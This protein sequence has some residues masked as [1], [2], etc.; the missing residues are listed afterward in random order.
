MLWS[1]ICYLLNRY[2]PTSLPIVA[3]EF[4]DVLLIT[5]AVASIVLS[6][7]HHLCL[8]ILALTFPQHKL[9]AVRIPAIVKVDEPLVAVPTRFSL[10]FRHQH[11][12]QFNLPLDLLLVICVLTGGEEAVDDAYDIGN[13]ADDMR[14]KVHFSNH[15]PNP[16]KYFINSY[17]QAPDHRISDA[18]IELT[19]H[20]TIHLI[21]KTGVEVMR[22]V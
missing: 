3:V 16:L 15:K 1:F 21:L 11:C 8:Y 9:L 14:T 10:H 5:I 4:D 13:G 12:V 20:L 19:P 6:P 7:D 22:S 18:L 2:C 17:K